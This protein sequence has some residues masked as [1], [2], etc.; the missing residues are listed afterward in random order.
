MQVSLKELLQKEIEKQKT[1][2]TQEDRDF[3]T[4]QYKLESTGLYILYAHTIAYDKPFLR[5]KV[6]SLLK[7]GIGHYSSQS[8][9]TIPSNL[10]H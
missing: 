2:I 5:E 1:L 9:H 10:I 8:G 7:R 3:I 6:N 4:S